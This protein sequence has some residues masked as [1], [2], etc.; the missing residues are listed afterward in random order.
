MKK[1]IALLTDSLIAN[2]PLMKIATYY[3]KNNVKWYLPLDTNIDKLYISKIFNYSNLEYS[4]NNFEIGGTGFDLKKKLPEK[5]EKCQP[6][7]N[8][9]PNC[10]YS[11]QYFS[12][13]CI[14]KCK[15]CIVPEKEGHI[16]PVEIMNLNPKGKYI[17]ILDNNFFANPLWKNAIKVLKIIKQPVNFDSGLDLRIFNEEQGE[18][19]KQIKIYKM[20]HTAWDN[21]KQDLT[22]KIKLM[23]KYIKAYKIMIYVLIGFDSTHEENYYRVMKIKELGCKPFVMPYNKKDKYQKRFARWVN[24][25]AIFNSVKWIDY[26]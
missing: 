4:I 21:P 8:I 14:R 25:M 17:R 7:Y 26:K 9:Y 2:L 6:D 5:I 16:Y 22:G 20:I 10:D 24:H 15:F 3:K 13:G 1:E 18:A 11:L 23:I 12:R 19:L